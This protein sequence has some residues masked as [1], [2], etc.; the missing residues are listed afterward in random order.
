MASHQC[1]WRADAAQASGISTAEC[2]ERK[3]Q[4]GASPTRARTKTAAAGGFKGWLLG[5]GLGPVCRGEQWAV[6]QVT[7]SPNLAQPIAKQLFSLP[8]GSVE[9]VHAVPTAIDA[10]DGVSDDTRNEPHRVWT[11]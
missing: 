3:G 1:R 5:W 2:F 10:I 9:A 8:L 7:T 4:Q 6:L 11:Q